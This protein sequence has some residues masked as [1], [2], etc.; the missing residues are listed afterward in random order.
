MWFKERLSAC[1]A[2]NG[3]R[4]GRCREHVVRV[5]VW[6][7]APIIAVRLDTAIGS[8]RIVLLPLATCLYVATPL[9]AHQLF[10]AQARLLWHQPYSR[11]EMAWLKCVSQRGKEKTVWEVLRERANAGYV[12]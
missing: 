12:F 1:W 2:S 4:R 3:V 10:R 9:P 6:E 5:F 8:S 11:A 7:S